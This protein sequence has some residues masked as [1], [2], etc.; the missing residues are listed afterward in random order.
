LD[1]RFEARRSNSRNQEAART[2]LNWVACAVGRSHH[3]ALDKTLSALSPFGGREATVLGRKERL[4]VMN[5]ALAN[6][7]SLRLRLR[8]YHLHTIIHPAGPGHR[9]SL[10]WRNT[11]PFRAASFCTLTVG[12]ERSAASETRSIPPFDA[13]WHITGTAEYS[14]PPQPL[15]AS[16]DYRTTNAMGH[17]ARGRPAG[18]VEEMFRTMTKAFTPAA[19]RKTDFGRIPGVENCPAPKMRSKANTVGPYAGAKRNYAEITDNS[20][21]LGSRPQYMQTVSL[22]DSDASVYRRLHQL[23]P[24]QPQARSD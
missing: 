9:R 11:N 8:R 17:R 6:G 24:V 20:A 19:L 16:S 5:A 3:E 22:R 2:L 12:I 13:G 4:D 21:K 1:R 14:P 18:R 15:A 7:M 10:Q 23:Q